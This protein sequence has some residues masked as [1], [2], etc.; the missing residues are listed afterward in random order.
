MPLK[1]GYYY[2][3]LP[4]Q[5]PPFSPTDMRKSNSICLSV[6]LGFQRIPLSL[7][8]M[9]SLIARTFLTALVKG[10]SYGSS[11][12]YGQVVGSLVSQ[13]KSILT[14][15]LSPLFPSSLSCPRIRHPYLIYCRPVLNPSFQD[16]SQSIAKFRCPCQHFEPQTTSECL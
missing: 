6:N 1:G 15:H 16:T 4:F 7:S 9:P 11:G 5:N 3:P 13:N 14:F 2:W 12:E 10:L 8:K